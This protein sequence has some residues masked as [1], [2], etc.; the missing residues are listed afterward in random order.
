VTTGAPDD[1]ADV[2][3]APYEPAAIVRAGIEWLPV[4]V[5]MVRDDGAITLVNRAAEQLLGY[6]APELAGQTIDLVVPSALRDVQRSLR[7]DADPQR[8]AHS[9]TIKS[10][11]IAR[12]KDGSHIPVDVELIPVPDK[13]RRFVLAAVSDASERRRA[14]NELRRAADDRIA[15]EALVAE[16][17]V[18]CVNLPLDDVDRTLEESLARL[19]RALDL[20][21]STLFQV[22]EESGD[23][24]HTHQWTR[25]GWPAPPPRIS[26][27]EQFPWLLSQVVAGELVSFTN[28]DEVPDEIDR[29]SL[30]RL[31][32]R[33]SV[34]VPLT[35]HGHAWGALT[36]GTIGELRAW[37]PELVNRLRVVALVFANVLARKER[38]YAVRRAL[39]ANTEVRDRLREENAYL[40]RE[41]QAVSGAPAIVGNSPGIRR[42]LEQVRQVAANDAAVLLHGETGTGKS[43]L[44]TRIHDLSPRRARALVRVHC[45]SLAV[46]VDDDLFGR[47]HGALLDGKPRQ[48]GLLEI[49]DGSTVLLDE[50]ADLPADTQANLARVLQH[51]EIQ[52]AGAGKPIKVNLRFAAVT[53][54]DLPARIAAGMFRD[55]L[56]YLLNVFSI[57]VPPL[58]ERSED[59]PLLVWR[60]VDEFSA[61]HGKVVD[62][63]DQESMARLQHYT[64]PG[65]ARELRNVVERAMI[66]S[67]ERRLRIPLPIPARPPSR[68]ADTLA[69]V[70]K[71]HIAT[72]LDACGGEIGGKRGAA[73]RLGLTP[74][75]LEAKITRLG[76]RRRAL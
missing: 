65:N 9:H 63:I 54:H 3:R 36:F 12:H 62:T 68:A 13:D 30:R 14:R 74:R 19:V 25:P 42:V 41:L 66:V 38:D 72:V 46:S 71:A 22:V 76:L 5:L 69:A 60:F 56:Y 7:D 29:E 27:R 26:A 48:V 32:T 70:E 37:T 33:S 8:R 39:S 57:E 16:L 75:A 59:I 67:E 55:D 44:A 11:L 43:L 53:R 6:S 40:R 52:P 2:G 49:A 15:F 50:V 21:R 10:E 28:V 18:E 73:A 34:I 1:Q 20:D 4:G 24:V 61:L 51:Q 47:D 17:A 35:V 31:G 64:W 45:A 58:R 23:F